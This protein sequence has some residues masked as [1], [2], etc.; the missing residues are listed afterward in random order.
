MCPAQPKLTD[1]D[2]LH[3]T[4]LRREGGVR[5][6]GFVTFGAPERYGVTANGTVNRGMIH[7]TDWFPTICEI[8]GCGT[9]IACLIA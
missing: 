9:S 3:P 5:G 1:C 2:L 4:D 7:V 8:A 6:T